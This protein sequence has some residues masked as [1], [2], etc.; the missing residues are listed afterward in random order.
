MESRVERK[1]P[2]GCERSLFTR[3]LRD[4]MLRAWN[5]R[6]SW[7]RRRRVIGK[8]EWSVRGGNRRFV[9]TSLACA[10]SAE[11]DRIY[12]ETYCARGDIE[13]RI[14]EQQLDLFADQT[15]THTLRANQT[16]L[17]FASFAYILLDALR[18]IGLAGL[19]MP[20]AKCGTIR[21]RL[22]NIGVRARI[23]ARRVWVHMTSACPLANEVHPRLAVLTVHVAAS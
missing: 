8:A 7:E 18:R 17:C 12:R 16:R 5:S 6:P 2:T 1:R 10:S 9:V 3:R 23:T 21:L 22:L 11:A 20:R 13:N 4:P 15:S 14:K 19:E